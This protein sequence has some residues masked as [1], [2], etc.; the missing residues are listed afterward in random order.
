MNDKISPKYQMKLVDDVEKAIWAQFSTYK[1]VK[2]YIQKWLVV[3]DEWNDYW[4]N[5]SIVEK[6]NKDI[7]LLSTLHTMNGEDLLKIAIDLGIET[8]D[9]IP[10]IPMFRNEIKSSFET[11]SATFERAFK[12]IEE[13]PDIAI[14][15]ANSALESIIKEILKDERITKKTK[16][17]ETLYGLTQ[18]ILK[19]FQIFPNSDLPIE[20]KTI[21]SALLSA[22]QNIEK[23]RSEKTDFHGKTYDDYYIKDP[24]YVYFVFNCVVTIGLFLNS[25]YRKKYPKLES[26]NTEESGKDDLPF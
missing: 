4:Q 16:D 11:A 14:G 23:I 19:E 22:T 15:L 9:F 6:E 25:F 13:H 5:F 3:R 2:F 12:Q 8:P 26:Q 20:I 1:K 7:D 18:N 10:S 24:I 21:G 17:G